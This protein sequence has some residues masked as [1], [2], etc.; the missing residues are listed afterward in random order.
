MNNCVYNNSYINVVGWS[1]LYYILY[2]GWIINKIRII[3]VY[4]YL[5]QNYS[6]IESLVR[7]F[8]YTF[9]SID[10]LI[11]YDGFSIEWFISNMIFS[12]TEWPISMKI[13]RFHAIDPNPA[14]LDLR[15]RKIVNFYALT[16]NFDRKSTLAPNTATK[17]K[18][19]NNARC[20]SFW[21]TNDR[22][23]V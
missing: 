2:I 13:I 8:P 18:F 3:E 1:P 17:T 15:R 14:V 21:V 5:K 7:D 23:I 16:T 20:F 11:F 4:C 19:T 12:S 22:H 9:A 6:F 10:N